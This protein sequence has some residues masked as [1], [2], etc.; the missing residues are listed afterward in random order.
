MNFITTIILFLTLI[1]SLPCFAATFKGTILFENGSGVNFKEWTESKGFISC[2]KQ[3]GRLFLYDRIIPAKPLTA[4][5]VNTYL[6]RQLKLRHIQPPYILVAHSYGALYSIYFARKYP[7][8]VKGILLVDPVPN[9]FEWQ[10]SVKKE[11]KKSPEQHYQLLGFEQ[12]KKQVNN[13]PPLS[14]H[15]PVIILSSSEME[16]NAPIKGDWYEQQQQWLNKN[17]E[18]KI[19]KV[20]GGHF[21]QLEHPEVVCEQIKA[22]VDLKNQ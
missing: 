20:E 9:N 1:F 18:S 6:T 2:A 5:D 22:L 17:P 7:D 4:S 8:S 19:I 14:N 21:I 15:I 10:D 13:L 12:T 16:K 11:K 3:S